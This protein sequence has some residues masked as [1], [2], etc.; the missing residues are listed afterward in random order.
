V[1]K[2]CLKL[3]DIFRPPVY[4]PLRAKLLGKFPA[5]MKIFKAEKITSDLDRIC[6]VADLAVHEAFQSIEAEDIQIS[7][8]EGN[9]QG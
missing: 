3:E 9:L 7:P 8:G 4:Q 5:S 6:P 1:P 2:S